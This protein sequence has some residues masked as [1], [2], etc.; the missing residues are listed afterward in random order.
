[1]SESGDDFPPSNRDVERAAEC[2]ETMRI[3]AAKL[4][5]FEIMNSIEALKAKPT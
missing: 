4:N 1:M 5:A 2:V 3:L